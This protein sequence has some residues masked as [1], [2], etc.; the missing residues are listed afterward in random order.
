MLLMFYTV[1]LDRQPS[2]MPG[3]L[4]YSSD[5]PIAPGTLVKVPL[6]NRSAEGIVI[7]E[8]Q[9]PGNFQVKPLTEILSENPILTAPLLKTAFLMCDYYCSSFRQALQV[10]LP[11]APWIN[12]IPKKPTGNEINGK[13]INIR[14]SV[15]YGDLGKE[16][17]R[18]LDDKHPS[19][20]IDNAP[21]DD[22]TNLYGN[23]A[24]KMYTAGKSTLILYP[25]IFSA[26]TAIKKLQGLLRTDLLLA[27]SDMGTASRRKIWRELP[28][29][30]PRIVVGTRTALFLPVSNLGLIILD[31]EQEW[32]YKSDQ[33]PRYHTRLT[34]EVLCKFSD[35]KLVLASS[36]PSL[37]SVCH[38]MPAGKE[39][40]RYAQVLSW[41]RANKPKNIKLVDMTS[42][43]FGKYYP[44]TS[45][46]LDAIDERMKKSEVSILL[47]NRR[48]A[49]S[50]LMCF[51][52]KKNVVS[53]VSNLP[54]SVVK[55]S[56]KPWL[57]DLKSG[58]KE[59]VPEICPYC[60]SP[61]LKAVGA[62]TQGVET[63]LNKLFPRARI[64]RADSDSTGRPGDFSLLL[65]GIE[66]GETDILIGTQPVV[67]ALGSPR[68]TLAGILIADTG[69][70]QPDF[71]SGEKVFSRLSRIIAIM[72]NKPSGLTF[73]Q[74]FRPTA[75]E[76][77]CSIEGRKH[78]YWDAEL[79][80]R[81]SAGYPPFSQ[82]IRLIIRGR[83]QTG[84]AEAIFKLAKKLSEA[85][86][87]KVSLNEEYENKRKLMTV[88]LRGN[89]PRYILRQL[90]LSGIVVDI[91]PAE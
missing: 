63:K 39:P 72:E 69:L 2:S 87:V 48:G 85:A 14:K 47:L 60:S 38:S 32:T 30:M 45:P 61:N 57:L 74:T 42:A 50:S 11:A 89:K 52:C 67:K 65:K 7:G 35:A 36:T 6:R 70:S 79:S 15:F 54:M 51:D 22:R 23:L 76:I 56:D 19:L 34:A 17:G 18:L 78:D 75:A 43:D 55:E 90:P 88:T 49:A 31:N 80:E 58:Y 53:P 84:R 68:A 20:F 66:S 82:M 5:Q 4:T 77:T 24:D 73:I 13:E 9:N 3:G 1:V 81:K 33:T 26:E 28:C 62:G 91:D 41:T 29:G 25:D 71:R 86:R 10:F 40:P 21:G 44:L 83:D 64:S 8:A 27:H 16:C 46:L 12:L 37:E 59:P